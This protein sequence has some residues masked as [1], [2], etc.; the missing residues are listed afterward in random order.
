MVESMIDWEGED[1]Q[2]ALNA[3]PP[4]IDEERSERP[5]VEYAAR[6]LYERLTHCDVP[7]A[8]AMSLHMMPLPKG[9]AWSKRWAELPEEQREY[10]IRVVH[11]CL[12]PSERLDD[13]PEPSA[14][15]LVLYP[16]EPIPG[17]NEMFG[18]DDLPRAVG[19]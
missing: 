11:E 2:R 15:I 17:Q 7:S 4:S 14:R 10:W 3:D 8:V 13:Q 9:P 18:S 6:V 19:V 1:M 12:V 16:D 5:T